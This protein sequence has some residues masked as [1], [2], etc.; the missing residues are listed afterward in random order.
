MKDRIRRCG[1]RLE[2]IGNRIIAGRA[3][4]AQT[5]GKQ[6]AQNEHQDSRSS[7]RKTF[8]FPIAQFWSHASSVSPGRIFRTQL[9]LE[10]APADF[11]GH[12][13]DQDAR[14]ALLFSDEMLTG[15]NWLRKLFREFKKRGGFRTVLRQLAH[16]TCSPELQKSRGM[17][18]KCDVLFAGH[19]SVPSVPQSRRQ[20]RHPAGQKYAQAV[21]RC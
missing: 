12:L 1:M 18:A 10:F 21:Y 9:P 8:P 2:N 14:L 15:S 13:E 6:Q 16:S 20:K 11:F 19:T 4:S 7:P 17:A 5:R 3:G